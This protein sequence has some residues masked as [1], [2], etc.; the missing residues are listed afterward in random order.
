MSTPKRKPNV[1]IN[2]AGKVMVMAKKCFD[3]ELTPAQ[4]QKIV[5]RWTEEGIEATLKLAKKVPRNLLAFT[6]WIFPRITQ[7]LN[8]LDWSDT[9][10]DDY[11]RSFRPAPIIGRDPMIEFRKENGSIDWKKFDKSAASIGELLKK[12]QKPKR[13]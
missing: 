9:R 8:M 12:Y 1:A 3:I 6:E 7:G 10:Y 13:S 4:A 11:K 2:N 5:N